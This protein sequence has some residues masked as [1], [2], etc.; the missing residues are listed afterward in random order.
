[1]HDAPAAAR[2]SSTDAST[3]VAAPVT[4]TPFEIRP[5]VH[6]LDDDGRKSG[7]AVHVRLVN[8]PANQRVDR[9]SC[10][11]CSGQCAHVQHPDQS[12]GGPETFAKRGERRHPRWFTSPRVSPACHA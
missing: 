3:P 12:A 2:T 10:V 1:M 9:I 11:R 8:G 4:T 5:V 6:V 7:L